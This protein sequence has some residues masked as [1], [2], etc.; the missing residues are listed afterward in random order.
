MA[1]YDFSSGLDL[2]KS[3]PKEYTPEMTQ[4]FF[5][6]LARPIE[7]QTSRNVGKA[8]GEA[9]RRGL[10]GDPFESLGVAKARTEGSNQ[11]ADLWS[12][13]SMQGAGMA[14]DER[15]T[16]EGR[17][18]Q[19]QEAQKSR[20]FMSTEAIANRQFAEHMANVGYDNIRSLEALQNRRGYQTELWNK[21]AELVQN[22]FGGMTESGG[23]KKKSGYSF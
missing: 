11:L 21:G 9:L 7:E 13:I 8:R 22:M 6:S 23:E 18:W 1:N 16:G 20:D 10:E 15:L 14:R 4:D 3:R 17:D 19:S 5:N 2:S 12:G